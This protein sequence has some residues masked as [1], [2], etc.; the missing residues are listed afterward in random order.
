MT[1]NEVNRPRLYAMIFGFFSLTAIYVVAQASLS[2]NR[3]ADK[4]SNIAQAAETTESLQ[5]TNTEVKQDGLP[6]LNPASVQIFKP[7]MPLPPFKIEEKRDNGETMDK[8]KNQ[9]FSNNSNGN[10]NSK[11]DSGALNWQIIKQKE[12]GTSQSSDIMGEDNEQEDGQP[13]FDI[14]SIKSGVQASQDGFNKFVGEF[15][16]IG[17][18]IKEFRATRNFIAKVNKKNANTVCPK[19]DNLLNLAQA[20]QDKLAS[21]STGVADGFKTIATALSMSSHVSALEASSDEAVA[22]GDDLVIDIGEEEDAPKFDCQA[23]EDLGRA[24]KMI[25]QALS[26]KINKFSGQAVR[27]INIERGYLLKLLKQADQLNDQK[28][29]SKFFQLF[30]QA[31]QTA[32]KIMMMTNEFLGRAINGLE[33]LN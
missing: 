29:P 28:D 14:S 10:S 12:E 9:N 27:L 25:S 13:D 7:P 23:A 30:G 24:N 21:A 18:L 15:K 33:E 17:P 16:N 8:E 22:S 2:L 4:I 20:L 6:L 3:D 26:Q 32:Q 11:R 5:T 31:E 1:Y 19:V